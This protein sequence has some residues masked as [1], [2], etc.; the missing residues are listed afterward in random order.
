MK[1]KD[2]DSDGD[3]SYGADS[4]ADGNKKN[5]KNQHDENMDPLTSA[6]SLARKGDTVSVENEN[7][8][9]QQHDSTNNHDL[10]QLK[11]QPPTPTNTTTTTAAPKSSN[12]SSLL[13][14]SILSGPHA[15][16]TYKLQP[17]HTQ[18]CLIGRSKGKKFLRNGISLSKDQEVSTTHGKFSVEEHEVDH[19]DGNNNM[20]NNNDSQGQDQVQKKFYYTDVGST[21][22][23]TVG[24]ARLEANVRVEIE[25]GME[26]RIGNSTL[27]IV[28]G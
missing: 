1:D 24:E 4:G 17:K 12:T 10:Q 19:D 5:V 11:Q 22:G 18:P 9:P 8:D 23:S 27:K 25:D 21:N 2:S 16:Q 15:S 26:L 14:I 20:D 13:I 6:L 7:M 28:F 3:N